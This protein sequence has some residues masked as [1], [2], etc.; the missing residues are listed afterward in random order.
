MDKGDIG[1]S[2]LVAAEGHDEIDGIGSRIVASLADS[3]R[4]KSVNAIMS[5]RLFLPTKMRIPMPR[6]EWLDS[7][8]M[9]FPV[10]DSV[11]PIS[12]KKEDMRIFDPS[13]F[14]H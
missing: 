8:F 11:A 1:R 10:H 2:I 9:G 14:P 5:C 6:N 4:P 13:Q 12:L 7:L 3:W